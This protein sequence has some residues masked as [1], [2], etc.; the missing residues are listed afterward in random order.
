V[1]K[2]LYGDCNLSLAPKGTVPPLLRSFV[3]ESRK[4]YKKF[5][6][7]QK[8][9]MTAGRIDELEKLGFDFDPMA[10]GK[11]K[12]NHDRRFALQWEE[13]FAHIQK[14]KAEHGDCLVSTLNTGEYAKLGSWVRGQ[15]K[16]LN[17]VGREGFNPERM[18]KLE[19][20]GFDFDPMRSEAFR[21][22]KRASMFP[23]I[24]ANWE[25]HHQHLLA[26][27]KDTGTITIGPN[28]EGYPGLYDW[29]HCQRKAYK[30][31]QA[32][33]S[34]CLMH[35]SWIK[36]LN[37]LGF[38]WAP[39]KNEEFTKMTRQKHSNRFAILWNQHY[40]DLKKY[41]T[42]HGHC[43]VPRNSDCSDEDKVLASWVH[44]QRKNMKKHD[45]GK[46]TPLTVERIKLL[47]D[48]DFDWA[49]AK[50]GGMQKR[51]LVRNDEEWEGIFSKLVSFK[52]K[53]GHACPKKV[54]PLLGSWACRMRMLYAQNRKGE[55]TTLSAEKIS[56]LESI[57]FSFARMRGADDCFD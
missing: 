11:S 28:T 44:V 13:N 36:K 18:E 49:P 21:A 55:T 30:K 4:Q 3:F 27:K 56:K 24:E 40:E 46:N 51:T 10:S 41:H 15:R 2:D 45:E 8:S 32:N 29:I 6:K 54:E 9:S 26:Y 33:D 43:Y 34:R 52:N 47:D 35:E 25:R 5:Q 14:Y 12:S 42:K 1:H 20:I 16:L 7:R 38:D 17:R 31:W 37:D 50:T 39:S 53:R 19:S 23:R 48:I 22:K 57:G